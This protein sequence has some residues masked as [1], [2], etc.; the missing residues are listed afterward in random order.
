ML[1]K[2]LDFFFKKKGDSPSLRSVFIHFQKLI[3]ANNRS[4]EIMSEMGEVLSG[5]Y[6]FDSKFIRDRTKE[7]LDNVYKMIVNLDF[8]APGKYRVL[9]DNFYE[10]KL[11]L[12]EEVKGNVYLPD[13]NYTIFYEDIEDGMVDVVGGKNAAL[14]S[15]KNK[16]GL[17]T[18]DGFVITTQGFKFFV[19]ASKKSEEIQQVLSLWKKNALSTDEA[20]KKLQKLILEVELTDDFEQ[21]IKDII[22]KL[23]VKMNLDEIYFAVR[24]SCIGEDSEHSFAG[25]YESFLGIR[26][27]ELIP[28]YKKVLAS[29]YS[30]RA[31][32]Y[33]K[34][35][36]I[37][38]KE[39]AMAVGCQ[40]MIDPKVS[41]VIYTLDV[42]SKKIDRMIVAAI[43]GLA[44]D[45]VGGRREGDIF[46]VDR[47]SPYNLIDVQVRPKRR[48][49]IF[50]RET[51]KVA[52]IKVEQDKVE[53]ACLDEEQV[54]YLA[55]NA[56]KLERYFKHPQDIEFCFNKDGELVILQSRN[57][58]LS[59]IKLYCNIE[60]LTDKLEVIFSNKGDIVQQGIAFG[61]VLKLRFDQEIDLKKLEDK[62][63]VVEYPS[64]R[65][66]RMLEYVNGVIADRGAPVGHLATI[67]REFRLPMIVNTRVA[68]KLLN[69]G[70]EITLNA[71]DNVVYKGIIK[72][73]CYY[74]FV[75]EKFEDTRE[76]RTLKRIFHKVSPLNLVEAGDSNFKAENCKTLHDIVRFI[77]E[78]AVQEIIEKSYQANISGEGSI[79]K[80]KIDIPLD[81]VIIDLEQDFSYDDKEIPLDCISSLPL[82][83][84]VQGVS[85]SNIWSREPVGVDFRGF[86]SS[87]SRTFS[88]HLAD[89]RFVGQNLAVVSNDYANISLRLGYHFTM[90]DTLVR[91][92]AADN[93]IYFRF[94]GG[95]T[96]SERRS[97]R[98]RLIEKILLQNDF[99]TTV[100]GDLVIG[101]LKGMMKEYILQKIFVLGVLVA[102]TRQL[103]VKLINDESIEYFL[104]EFKNLTEKIKQKQ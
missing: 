65:L 28:T 6:I 66:A 62:I 22:H 50:D 80:L 99:F 79:K 71:T 55:Q 42:R 69:D 83:S 88:P 33:R 17:P 23:K 49:T 52:E 21:E 97:R 39:I 30:R 61:K 1:N 20:S 75:E 40:V 98:A 78:K 70:D 13:A 53:T 48:T 38:E 44:V 87:L 3:Q 7:L 29:T 104:Q 35:K 16:L 77:H 81:L 72:N 46:Y 14:A 93:Y 67:A 9:F 47:S 54:K 89:P 10:I 26:E 85:Y 5:E 25:L 57:L 91:E 11:A 19:H 73:L 32:E 100:K 56:I 76:Y 4:L 74:D 58:R 60:N 101:R 2:I 103:D 59:D 94:F 15:I 90:L 102:Y 45:I 24:S 43:Y 68:T 31:M 27:E 12:E 92:R 51:G 18:P 41:G 84:F 8:I 86:M 96:E 34:R 82:K 64:P 37:G 36:E 95:V 63:L